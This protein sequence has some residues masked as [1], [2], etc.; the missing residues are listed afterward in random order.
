M[1]V[2]LILL[3]VLSTELELSLNKDE[4]VAQQTQYG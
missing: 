1:E 2:L 4:M 3:F